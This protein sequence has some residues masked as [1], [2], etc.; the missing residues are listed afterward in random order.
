M[1]QFDMGNLQSPMSG[2]VLINHN[3]EPWRDALNS[4]HKGDSR[5]A[6]AVAGLMWLDD[7]TNP[8]LGNQSFYRI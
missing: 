6:Y 7:A 1:T 2:E 5:P 3:L 4:M 8:C